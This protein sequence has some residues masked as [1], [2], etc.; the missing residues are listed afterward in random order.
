MRQ[1]TILRPLAVN[2]AL[3]AV[4]SL[5]LLGLATPSSQAAVK[6]VTVK[7]LHCSKSTAVD[8]SAGTYSAPKKLLK[9]KNYTMRILTNCG[10]IVATLDGKNAPITVTNMSFLAGKKCFDNTLCHRLTTSGIDV[11]QCGDPTGTGTGGPGFAYADENLPTKIVKGRYPAGTI[12]MAN[13][14]PGTNGSQFFLVW[15]DDTYDLP[16]SYTIWGHITSGLDILKAIG[17]KG[18][19]GGGPDGAPAQTVS[20][21]SL[22]IR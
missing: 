8:H 17:A 11:L 2:I 15:A 6:A 18:V 5:S 9:A 10:T 14:G 20:I 13:A 22:T 1:S 19:A 12:A 7:T 4:L 21:K 3:S 16:A